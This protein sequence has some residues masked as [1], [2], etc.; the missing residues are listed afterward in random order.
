[1]RFGSRDS[2]V[3]IFISYDSK[4][5]YRAIS[6]FHRICLIRN[7]KGGLRLSDN[8]ARVACL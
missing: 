2:R 6:N 3:S 5:I 7:Y 8:L 1:M 4:N